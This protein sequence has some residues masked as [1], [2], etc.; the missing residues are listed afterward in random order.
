MFCEDAK[1]MDKITKTIEP[2]PICVGLKDTVYEPIKNVVR[3][4]MKSKSTKFILFF[5]T[6][7][8]RI[9]KILNTFYYITFSFFFSVLNSRKW[10]HLSFLDYEEAACY[11]M[12]SLP[13]T[14]SL[15]KEPFSWYFD[16]LNAC[17][18]DNANRSIP[19]LIDPNYRIHLGKSLEIILRIIVTVYLFLSDSL[20]YSY[21]VKITVI[22]W[23]LNKHILDTYNAQCRILKI[24]QNN[25]GLQNG[26]PN[27]VAEIEPEKPEIRTQEHYKKYRMK[28]FSVSF[29][30]SHFFFD[31]W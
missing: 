20:V 6:K 13:R 30:F 22:C 5:H 28:A 26:L 18:T 23:F 11:L 24:S 8:L 19:E 27:T 12:R 21:Y 15:G 25:S 16:F 1:R 29:A 9:W 4:M 31:I 2:L 10:I 17:L 7:W 3:G 14:K